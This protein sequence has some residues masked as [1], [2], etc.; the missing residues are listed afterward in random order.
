MRL[1]SDT[2]SM[3]F[4]SHVYDF[5]FCIFLPLSGFTS[6]IIIRGGRESRRGS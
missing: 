1:Y 6:D 2:Y 5:V 3:F 4:F